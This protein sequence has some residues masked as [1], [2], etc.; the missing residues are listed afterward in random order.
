M[1][2]TL[3]LTST[4]IYKEEDYVLTEDEAVT[5]NSRLTTD[6]MTNLY[7]YLKV[8]WPGTVKFTQEENDEISLLET[9]LRNY[10]ETM[11]SKMINGD[12]DI[13]ATW[14]E[15]IKGLN[16]RKLDRYVEL[17]QTAYDRWAASK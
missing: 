10:K 1:G 2:Q 17:L 15:Y 3:A 8:G 4:T 9:D 11:E 5:N 7:D 14:D 13:D 16:D 6:I 12:L